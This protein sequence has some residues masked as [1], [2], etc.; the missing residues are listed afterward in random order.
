LKILFKIKLQP[1]SQPWLY[2]F[3]AFFLKCNMNIYIILYIYIYIYIYIYLL[4]KV[5]F[6]G[7][8]MYLDVIFAKMLFQITTSN[9]AVVCLLT[10]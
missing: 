10:V 4:L 5:L 2:K 3:V 7:K 1:V 6:F 9:I 8:E